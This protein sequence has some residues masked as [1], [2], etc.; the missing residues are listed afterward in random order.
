VWI[1]ACGR[2]CVDAFACACMSLCVLCVVRVCCSCVR[3]CLCAYAHACVFACM[4]VCVCMCA[5]V[6]V[7]VRVCVCVCVRMFSC[8]SVFL[9]NYCVR[10]GQSK[11]AS[12]HAA[13]LEADFKALRYH[14]YVKTDQ[15]TCKET[16]RRDLLASFVRLFSYMLT[17]RSLFIR[18]MYVSAKET[19][20][21]CMCLQKRPTKEIC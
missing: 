12:T 8:L 18:S 7:C 9:V 21:R 16:H 15:H 3:A 19:Y 14:T 2:V 5:C 20:K 13:G 4:Y 17:Y 1:C 11:G 10:E 6:F